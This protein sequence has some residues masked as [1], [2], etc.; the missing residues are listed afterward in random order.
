MGWVEYHKR[1]DKKWLMNLE[2]TLEQATMAQRV[3]EV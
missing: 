1:Q 3:V 2:F